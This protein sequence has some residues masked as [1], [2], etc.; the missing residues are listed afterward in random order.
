MSGPS[1]LE[2]QPGDAAIASTEPVVAC[3]SLDVGYGKL[4]VARDI[5]FSLAPNKVL[6]IL[7][8]NGAGKTTLLM[9]LAG[10]LAPRSGTIVLNGQ[11]VKGA[12]PRRMNKAGLVLVPDSRA[13]FTELTPVQNLKLAAPAGRTSSIRCWSSSLPSEEGSACALPTSRAASSRCSPSPG[14]SCRHPGCS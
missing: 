1:A 6:T 7:G 13:L 11:P 4:T 5:T 3:Q 8:P 9:T 12:S 10:F 2:Q 14:P